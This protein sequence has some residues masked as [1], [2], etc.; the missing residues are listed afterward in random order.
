[1]WPLLF[2]IYAQLLPP[3]Q[4][5]SMVDFADKKKKNNGSKYRRTT[6]TTIEVQLFRRLLYEM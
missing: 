3:R 1:M 4:I 5:E 6:L 2:T